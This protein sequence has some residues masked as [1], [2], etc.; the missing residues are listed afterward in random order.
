MKNRLAA[1]VAAVAILAA[2]TVFA[3][4]K[5]SAPATIKTVFVSGH[6]ESS[7]ADKVNKMHA[8]M[9]AKGWKF[10]DLDIYTENSDMQGIFVTYV[11]DAAPA[12]AAQ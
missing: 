4:D 9:A 1:C 7:M 2:P 12:P 6:G 5:E 3:A 10:A 8:E 11:R